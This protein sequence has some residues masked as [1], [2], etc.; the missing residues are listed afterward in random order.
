MFR[1]AV[2]DDDDDDDDDDDEAE[3]TAIATLF[4]GSYSSRST[5]VIKTPCPLQVFHHIHRSSEG[6]HSR[7][8][9]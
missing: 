4:C 8:C 3:R 6:P 7:V 2:R 5:Y 1:C 9:K